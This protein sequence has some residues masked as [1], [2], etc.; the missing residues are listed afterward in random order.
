MEKF[1]PETEATTRPT[2]NHPG[3]TNPRTTRTTNN[4]FMKT[5][6]SSYIPRMN[7]SGH[8]FMPPGISSG[9]TIR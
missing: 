3:P 8:A 9:T 6:S 1:F 7:F 5:F 4:L 2:L